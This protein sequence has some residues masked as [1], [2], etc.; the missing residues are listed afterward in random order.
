MAVLVLEQ[1]DLLDCTVDGVTLA[2][3]F[4]LVGPR[5]ERDASVAVS[6]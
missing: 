2:E 3:K 5:V 6:V 1:K 4:L